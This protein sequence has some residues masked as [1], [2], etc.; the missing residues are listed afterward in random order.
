M[1]SFLA[2]LLLFVGMTMVCAETIYV[3]EDYEV[4]QA[5]I[6]AAGNGDVVLVS[7]GTYYENINFNGKAITVAS[8]YYTT[9]DTSYISQTVIDGNQAGSVVTFENGENS[10]SHLTG[11]TIVNGNARYGGGIYCYQS[12]FPDLNDLIIAHNTASSCGG[13]ITCGESSSPSLS[14]IQIK[15]N[16]AEYGGGLYCYSNSNPLLE[17]VSI[18]ENSADTRGGGISCSNSS[19]EF[20]SLYR[21]SIYCNNTINRNAG[22][23]IST[24]TAIN[25]IV[26]TF[27][28]LNPTNYHAMPLE[29]FTFDILNCIIEPID[30]DL[31]VSPTGNNSNS[32]LSAEEPLQ[33]I[34][35]A[36]S[37]IY[38]SEES[39][40]NIYLSEGTFSPSTNNEIFPI[41]LPDNVTLTGVN[42]TSTII[43]AEGSSRVMS[44][45][46]ANNIEISNLTLCNGNGLFGGGMNITTSNARIF[47]VSILNNISEN[48]GGG[49]DCYNCSL[50]LENVTISGNYAEDCG[51][52][53]YLRNDNS[54]LSNV[55]ITDNQAGETGGGIYCHDANPYLADVDLLNNYSLR[56]GGGLYIDDG[57]F[58]AFSNENRSNIYLN[59]A[60]NTSAGNDIFSENLVTIC[61]DTFTVL[62]PTQFHTD[63][64][65]NFSF[66]ILNGY[67]SQLESDIFVSP[68]GDVNNSGSSPEEPV[69]TIQQALSMIIVTEDSPGIIH[70]LEGCYSPSSNGEIFP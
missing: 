64:L 33:T 27:T 8:L 14:N 23:D 35:Y 69:L 59:R 39:P 3:P 55:T 48:D 38:T 49:M 12:V 21:S 34:N 18:F 37:R 44:L 46:Y 52:G 5:A 40:H 65:D 22:W 50:D 11:F 2:F 62:N 29:L 67:Y 4:I 53:I 68:S 20:S 25:V 54:S 10:N 30:A 61:V 32:G 66:D 56:T 1:R 13:G 26:D 45:Y 7:P 19:P 43:D 63:P 70:L 41:S 60:R 31:Y 51:G 24:S 16:N 47:N 17:N 42:E 6:N 15:Y 36:S 28:V 9:Q 57:S 58:P